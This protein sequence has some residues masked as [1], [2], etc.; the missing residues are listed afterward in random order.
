MEHILADD[1]W[2]QPVVLIAITLLVLITA[3]LSPWI[4]GRKA[5]EESA[6]VDDE[7]VVEP[8]IRKIG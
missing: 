6:V 4:F 2:K 1:D 7:D 5:G 3:A 8:K